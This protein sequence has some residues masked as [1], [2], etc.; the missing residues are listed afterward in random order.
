M[1]EF[2]ALLTDTGAALLADAV[3]RKDTLK[4]THMSVGDGN[5]KLPVPT[6]EQTK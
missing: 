1:T 4:L 6:P 3:A 5:G 2:F